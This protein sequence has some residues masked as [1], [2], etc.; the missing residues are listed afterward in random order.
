MSAQ[1]RPLVLLVEDNAVNAEL[2]RTLLE[3]AGFEVLHAATGEAALRSARDAGPEIILMDLR[4][5]DA[6]GLALVRHLRADPVLSRTAIVAL[7]AYAMT[8]D[9]AKAL[10]AGCDGYI[11]KPFDTRSFADRIRAILAARRQS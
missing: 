6:D 8:G 3:R 2:A 1:A 4:L 10:D 9:E 11:A 5:P 7:T